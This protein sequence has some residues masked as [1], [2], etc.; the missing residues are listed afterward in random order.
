MRRW[1]LIILFSFVGLS[2]FSQLIPDSVYN[3]NIKPYRSNRVKGFKQ[4]K[5]DKPYNI[6]DSLSNYLKVTE[7][8]SFDEESYLLKYIGLGI[9]V[10]I[11]EQKDSICFTSSNRKIL[12]VISKISPF[13]T[14]YYDVTGL[15][16]DSINI[17][18]YN[19]RNR[20]YDRSS[21][22]NAYQTCISYAL[23][24]IFK[25]NGIDPYP[26]FCYKTMVHDRDLDNITNVLLQKVLVFDKKKADKQEIPD[27][28]FILLKNSKGESLHA[29]FY[30]DKR[31]WTKN[32]MFPY[33]SHEKLSDLLKYSYET[34][35]DVEIYVLNNNIFTQKGSQSL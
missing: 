22:L 1:I 8:K 5:L 7:F 32:G 11:K 2:V 35:T 29:C 19:L 12:K 3:I 15:E 28:S 26:I 20:N 6:T 18:S 14:Y 9:S 21:L 16:N 24:N 34:T 27:K 31:I 4:E 17:I 13:P 23:E 25:Y 33:S 10:N 30:M